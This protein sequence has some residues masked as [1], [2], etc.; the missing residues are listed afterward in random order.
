MMRLSEHDCGNFTY[1]YTT[2]YLDKED[3]VWILE[4]DSQSACQISYCPF[5]GE[6]L[7]IKD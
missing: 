3:N 5:C 4:M 7:E 1:E 6:K 2:I